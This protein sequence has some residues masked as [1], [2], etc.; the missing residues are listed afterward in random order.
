MLICDKHVFKK[1]NLS[2]IA[3]IYIDKIKTFMTK[4]D[5]SIKNTISLHLKDFTLSVNFLIK[6]K[7]IEDLTAKFIE[8][9]RKNKLFTRILYF[10]YNP[11]VLSAISYKK[12]KVESSSVILHNFHK[13]NEK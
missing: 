11:N 7:I 9:L 13:D 8:N 5:L 10:N 2:R 4:N 3:S 12:L 6:M 1:E